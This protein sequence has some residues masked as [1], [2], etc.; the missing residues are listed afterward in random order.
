MFHLKRS[1]FTE[2]ELARAYRV[3]LLPTL[4][5]CAPVY[6]SLLTDLQD[7]QLERLQASALHCIYGYNVPYSL[8]RVKA[9]VTTL[10]QRR[11][12]A[13]D[14]FTAKC[15]TSPMFLSWFP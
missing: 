13:L 9:E 15:L 5:Y 14:K 3:C 1:G 12:E 10:R 4:D 2:E 6:H 7:Q 8:M 11:I